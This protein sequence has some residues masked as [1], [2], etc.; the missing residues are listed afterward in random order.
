MHV[1]TDAPPHQV[2]DWEKEQV[3][4]HVLKAA[5]EMNRTAY[6]ER[7]KQIRMSEHDAAMYDVMSG[8]VRKQVTT[9]GPEHMAT[10]ANR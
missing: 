3:P 10:S 9:Y 7:L 6:A 4:E 5:R 2:P 1:L 8:N